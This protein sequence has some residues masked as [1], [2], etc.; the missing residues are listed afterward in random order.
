MSVRKIMENTLQLIWLQYTL[1][2]LNCSSNHTF[3]YKQS[4]YWSIMMQINEI[5]NLFYYTRSLVMCLFQNLLK[6]SMETCRYQKRFP[7]CY[8]S[9]QISKMPIGCMTFPA[10]CRL[11]LPPSLSC[12]RDWKPVIGF[13]NSFLLFALSEWTIVVSTCTGVNYHLY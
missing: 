3:T 6:Q 8:F 12:L 2:T 5:K 10:L 13:H 1:S 9:N 7:F 11:T 4:K